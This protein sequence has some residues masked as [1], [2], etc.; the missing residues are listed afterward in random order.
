MLVDQ[1]KPLT[2]RP[3]F[4][5]GGRLYVGRRA[6]LSPSYSHWPTLMEAIC[7]SIDKPAITLSPTLP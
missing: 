6:K 7:W 4:Q 5:W 1:A 3:H 2:L